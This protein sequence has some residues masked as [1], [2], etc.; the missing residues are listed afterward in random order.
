[1][2]RVHCLVQRHLR[3]LMCWDSNLSLVPP[4]LSY[5]KKEALLDRFPVGTELPLPDSDPVISVTDF[6][7]TGFCMNHDHSPEVEKEFKRWGIRWPSFDYETNLDNH[8]CEEYCEV[9]LKSGANPI[10]TSIFQPRNYTMMGDVFEVKFV[11][12]E[13]SVN[14]LHFTIP[15]WWSRK[16]ICFMETIKKRLDFHATSREAFPGASCTPIKFIATSA[17]HNDS[18][19]PT[20]LSVL[21]MKPSM[22]PEPEYMRS[23]FP[24]KES[25]FNCYPLGGVVNNYYDSDNELLSDEL[26]N[27]DPKLV[28]PTLAGNQQKL[29][30]LETPF[31]KEILTLKDGSQKAVTAFSDFCKGILDLIPMRLEDLQK[32]KDDINNINTKL[33]A[34]EGKIG[35]GDST[36]MSADIGQDSDSL[37]AASDIFC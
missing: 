34:L 32:A 26:L 35:G 6:E 22:I 18:I 5:L 14:E 4:S 31:Q 10:Y 21:G 23:I 33:V 13:L 9:S 7:I 8:I 17:I 29:V 15:Q 11:A 1:M 19:L 20:N 16:T 3:A 25:E 2:T 37:P 28:L 30:D 12:G 36:R 27:S 24:A